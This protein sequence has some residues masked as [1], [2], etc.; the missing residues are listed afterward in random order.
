M[1]LHKF[2]PLTWYLDRRGHQDQGFSDTNEILYC[3]GLLENGKQIIL[4][5]NLGSTKILI[6]SEK[7]EVS[8]LEDV[9]STY[10]ASKILISQINPNAIILRNPIISSMDNWISIET[11]PVGRVTSFFQIKGIN[12]YDPFL[13]EIKEGMKGEVELHESKIIKRL[14]IPMA[15]H[16]LKR[17]YW[18]IE[19]VTPRK[20]FVYAKYIDNHIISISL[21]FQNGDKKIS[22]FLYWGT[23]EVINKDFTS[24]IFSKESDMIIRFF[25]L[26]VEFSPDRMY[27]YNGDSFDIPYLIE[28]CTL[29]DIIPPKNFKFVNKRIKGRFQWENVKAFDT[30]SIEHFDILR[31]MLRFYPGLINYRLETIARLFL[32]EGKT[33]LEIEEMFKSFYI[34]SSTGIEDLAKYSV[35]DSLLLLKLNEKLKFDKLME[36]ISNSCGVICSQILD[37]YDYELINKCAFMVDPGSYSLFGE[38]SEHQI[39]TNSVIKQ[40]YLYKDIYVYDYSIYYSIEMQRYQSKFNHEL[41]N[42][43]LELHSK[44]KADLYWSKY[45]VK[46]ESTEGNYIS[47][48]KLLNFDNIIEITDITIKSI[49]PMKDLIEGSLA[50]LNRYSYYLQLGKLSYAARE[51]IDGSI[52]K[53]GTKKEL[54][55]TFKMSKDYLD[56]VLNYLFSDRSSGL[57]LPE[58]YV[59]DGTFEDYEI[60]IK[61]KDIDEYPVGSDK[62]KLASQ[63]NQKIKTWTR[64]K[65]YMTVNGPILK[66]LYNSEVLETDFYEKELKNIKKLLKFKR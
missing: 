63:F 8:D 2:Y 28:R 21:I 53:A 4:K 20:E 65:Y 5:I 38:K 40:N 45:F 41:S 57:E 31:I 44:L 47:Q 54:K 39:N 51:A 3:K 42:R 9:S 34:Q 13:I 11:D 14:D 60:D 17:I 66:E 12:P 27:T 62:W 48:L 37:L 61:L 23:Y 30:K 19:V 1:N 6:S 46:E 56:Q 15:S 33:G 29:H 64:V 49:G 16:N 58:Y 26:I 32:G 59:E 50:L 35:K 52:I 10:S 18:D 36:T 22:Y 55:P 7:I 24:I 43:S 25:E